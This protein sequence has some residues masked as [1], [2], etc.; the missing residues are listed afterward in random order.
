MQN[1]SVVTMRAIKN[2]SPVNEMVDIH[3]ENVNPLWPIK[4]LKTTKKK[5]TDAKAPRA[6]NKQTRPSGRRATAAPEPETHDTVLK[7][8]LHPD[9]IK[10]GRIISVY[11]VEELNGAAGDES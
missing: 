4:P 5:V 6:A 9:D 8:Q 7:G 3:G 1:M 11:H 10:R 2:T